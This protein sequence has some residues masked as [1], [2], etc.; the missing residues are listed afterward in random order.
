MSNLNTSRIPKSYLECEK[1]LGS[2][3]KTKVAHNTWLLMEELEHDGIVYMVK[4]HNTVI[5]FFYSSGCIGISNGGYYTA[6]TK[7]RLNAILNQH[8]YNIDQ[9]NYTWYIRNTTT[10][11]RRQFNRSCYLDTV[12]N[13]IDGV[14]L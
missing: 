8:G 14:Y 7:N 4:Y 3:E 12:D 1:T 5:A 10:Q 2:K 13:S 11:E 9:I 6:T